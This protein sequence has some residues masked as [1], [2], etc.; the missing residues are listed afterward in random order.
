[1]KPRFPSRV[2]G[3]MKAILFV[4]L[5]ACGGK[6]NTGGPSTGSGSASE[7]PPPLK[8]TRTE[9]EKRL[10]TACE[11]VGKKLTQCA[12]DS[13]K[14]ELDAGKMKKT[15]FDLNTKPEILEKHTEEF[16]KK[17]NVPTMSSRQVRVLEVCHK[18]ETEC[19]P[20]VDCLSHL[21]E[22]PK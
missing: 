8:D 5:V 6:Q 17:C 19:A 7:P 22:P 3:G 14:A 9:L 13:A 1:M 18:E 20:F 15:D 12:Y 4:V 11:S 21:N 2:R 16:V 10:A